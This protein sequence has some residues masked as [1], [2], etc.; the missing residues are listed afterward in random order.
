MNA[1]GGLLVLREG[2]RG[3]ALFITGRLS[4]VDDDDDETLTYVQ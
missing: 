2:L 4:A 3:R 1:G